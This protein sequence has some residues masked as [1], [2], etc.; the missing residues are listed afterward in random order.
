MKSSTVTEDDKQHLSGG[1]KSSPTV[2]RENPFLTRGTNLSTANGGEKQM[3]FRATKFANFSQ[4]KNP[5]SL[6]GTK[7]SSA[8]EKRKSLAITETKPPIGKIKETFLSFREER[9]SVLFSS[10]PSARFFFFAFQDHPRF[11]FSI[12]TIFFFIQ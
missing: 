3:P 12:E 4:G 10:R 2:A 8:M 11:S 5:F 9:F 7:S 1:T 6:G